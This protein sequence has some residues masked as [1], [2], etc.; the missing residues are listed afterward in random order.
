MNTVAVINKLRSKR[1]VNT[2]KGIKWFGYHDLK[3]VEGDLK[4]KLPM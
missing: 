2:N 4:E 1:A 3:Q